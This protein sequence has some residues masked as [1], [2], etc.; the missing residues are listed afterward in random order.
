MRTLIGVVLLAIAL[1]IAAPPDQTSGNHGNDVHTTQWGL[2]LYD[3]RLP[4]EVVH[5]IPGLEWRVGGFTTDA[6]S[7]IPAAISDWNSALQ[8]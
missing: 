3:S 8:T 4:P 2:A 7:L 1:A 5:N 6:V